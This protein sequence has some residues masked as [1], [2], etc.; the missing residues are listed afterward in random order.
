MAWMLN[1]LKF[2]FRLLGFIPVVAE[3]LY[4]FIKLRFAYLNEK[5]KLLKS[6]KE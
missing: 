4:Y 6:K 1:T 3:I 5:I 2:T